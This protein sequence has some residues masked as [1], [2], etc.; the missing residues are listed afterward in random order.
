[1]SPR[2]IRAGRIALVLIAFSLAFVGIRKSNQAIRYFSVPVDVTGTVTASAFDKPIVLARGNPRAGVVSQPVPSRLDVQLKEHPGVLYQVW[3]PEEPSQ[4]PALPAVGD[5]VTLVLP[6][7]WQE[8]EVGE[9]VLAFGLKQG[10]KVLV[11]PRAYPYAAEYRTAFLAVGAL[12]GA[13]VAAVGA[14][15]MRVE[16]TP[17]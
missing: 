2:L 1:M 3:L 14:I 17:T 16:T 5:T 11:D 12:L 6:V 10:D 8:L 15:R 13:L 9:R 7:R 4:H